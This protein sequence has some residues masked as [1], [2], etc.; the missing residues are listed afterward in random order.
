MDVAA[1]DEFE[2]FDG[3]VVEDAGLD[4]LALDD[5]GF[6]GVAGGGVGYDGGVEAFPFGVCELVVVEFFELGAEVV[7]EVV[8]GVEGEVVVGLAL[9]GCDE[10]GFELGFGLVGA[11]LVGGDGDFAG[12]GVLFGEQDGGDGVG[13]VVLDGHGFSF[14]AGSEACGCGVKDGVA[15]AGMWGGVGRGDG[16]RGG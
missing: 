15:P 1:V 8:C 2:V 4:G 16:V 11:F 13:W 7:F 9:E 5:F 14:V 12:D 3:S 10:L 6:V